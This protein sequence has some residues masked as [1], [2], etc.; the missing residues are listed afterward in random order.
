LE[1]GTGVK[2][3][4]FFEG[5]EVRENGNVYTSSNSNTKKPDGTE[6]AKWGSVRITEKPDGSTITENGDGTWNILF[7]KKDDGSLKIYF[8]LW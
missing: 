4:K 5:T 7:P 8:L 2:T 6:I 1:E 3:T